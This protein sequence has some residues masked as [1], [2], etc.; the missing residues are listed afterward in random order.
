MVYRDRSNPLETVTDNELFERYRFRRSTIEFIANSI[1]HRLTSPMRRNN[2]ILL[3]VQILRFREEDSKRKANGRT[4]DV[5]K[6]MAI[7]HLVLRKT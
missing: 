2:P 5:R 6:V 1:C 3:I 4:D 7:A